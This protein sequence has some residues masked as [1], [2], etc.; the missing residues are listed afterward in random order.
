MNLKRITFVNFN[1]PNKN[2]K[3]FKKF[4]LVEHLSQKAKNL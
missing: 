3:I 4:R 1:F 2:V